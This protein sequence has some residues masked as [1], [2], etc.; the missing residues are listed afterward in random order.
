MMKSSLN[1]V[2]TKEKNGGVAKAMTLGSKEPKK[3]GA[4]NRGC[5]E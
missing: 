1:F 5:R 3:R 2:Q 4:W